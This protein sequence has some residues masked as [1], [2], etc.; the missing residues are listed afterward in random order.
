MKL[1]DELTIDKI[2][3]FYY[4]FLSM[5]DTI[6]VICFICWQPAILTTTVCKFSSSKISTKSSFI[7]QNDNRGPRTIFCKSPTSPLK[8]NKGHIS[9]LLSKLWS[10]QQKRMVSLSYW[11]FYNFHVQCFNTRNTARSNIIKNHCYD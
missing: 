9:V 8:N 3:Q 11:F 7:S 1:L 10:L 4:I 2:L 5:K 6:M